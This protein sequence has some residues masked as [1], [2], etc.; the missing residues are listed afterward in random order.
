MG[1]PVGYRNKN[2]GNLRYKASWNWPGVVG[3]DD[4]QFAIFTSPEDGI[5]AWIRQMRRYHKRG[6]YTLEDIIPVYAPREDNNDEGAYI[7]K[8]AAM[9]GVKPNQPLNWNDKE[10][11]IA[12]MKAFTKHELGRLP[13][14][15]LSWYDDAVYLRGWDKAKPLTQ[16][17]TITGAV[18]AATSAAVVIAD[19]VVEVAT[20]QSDVIVSTGTAASSLWPAYGTIIAGV[21][22]LCCIVVVIYARMQ[23]QQPDDVQ[24]IVESQNE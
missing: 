4:R 10:Q 12:L 15:W 21:V 9:A 7:S 19:A 13:D 18:G 14:G 17:R 16:S 2:P 6:L 11:T 5:A 22:G 8:V 24:E 23:R 1:L 3:I 20:T